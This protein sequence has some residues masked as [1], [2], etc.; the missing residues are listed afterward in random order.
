M[1]IWKATW[2]TESGESEGFSYGETR[3][4]ALL[5]KPYP[6][7]SLEKSEKITVYYSAKGIVNA[8]NQHGSH[9]DNG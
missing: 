9:P 1:Q 2:R 7:A 5:R 4:T 3:K 8:L 6:D